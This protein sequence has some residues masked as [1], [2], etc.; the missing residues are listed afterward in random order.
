LK[1]T[2]LLVPLDGLF[3]LP[4]GTAAEVPFVVRCTSPTMGDRLLEILCRRRDLGAAHRYL[5][6]LQGPGAAERNPY[7]GMVCDVRSDRTQIRTAIRLEPVELGPVS[8]DQLVLPAAVWEAVD[9]NVHRMFAAAAVL[10][11]ADLGARRGLLVAGPPGVGKSALCRIVAKEV[12]GAA[13]VLI[14]DMSVARH[15]L[16]DLYREA[17]RAAPTLVILEELD[18]IAA[19]RGTS[20][21]STELSQFLA[22]T[23]GISTPDEVIVTLATTNVPEA[24]DRAAIRSARFDRILRLELPDRAGREATLRR[25]LRGIEADVDP[26]VVASVTTGAS[27]SDLRELVRLAVLRFG[28][29]VGTDDVVRLARETASW[30]QGPPIGSYL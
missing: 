12:A 21:M 3:A 26:A 19:E 28:N 24:L 11:G 10:R 16:E 30:R 4:A 20:A 29:D 5:S 2:E 27:G 18:G 22:A 25:Y 1:G 9:E 6:Y 23:D 15:D 7:R 13:T 8:R 17:A 14:A